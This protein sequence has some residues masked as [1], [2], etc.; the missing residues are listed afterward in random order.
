MEPVNDRFSTLT[1]SVYDTELVTLSTPALA[2][3]LIESSGWSTTK[4]SLPAVPVCE[5][6]V[7]C[8]ATSRALIS[9]ANHRLPFENSIASMPPVAVKKPGIQISSLPAS[10]MTNASAAYDV[11][12]H[13]AKST[14]VLEVRT[15]VS[16]DS[17][18]PGPKRITS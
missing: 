17:R 16:S 3:S 11:L 7:P 2:A 10:E 6:T 13:P 5:F 12:N 14:G 18:I 4:L 9:A 15:N 1:G 8:A